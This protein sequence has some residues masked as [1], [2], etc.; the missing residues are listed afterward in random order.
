MGLDL[1][2]SA[3]EIDPRQT[4]FGTVAGGFFASALYIGGTLFMWGSVCVLWVLGGRNAFLVAGYLALRMVRLFTE[5]Y[6]GVR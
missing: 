5:R 6:V 3:G 2:L 4:D 1:S